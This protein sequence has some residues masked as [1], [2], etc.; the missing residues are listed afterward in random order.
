MMS[1]WNKPSH[2]L[3]F[4]TL[5]MKQVVETCHLATFSSGSSVIG[6]ITIA[7]TDQFKRYRKNIL[8]DRL[9]FDLKF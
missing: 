5:H 8:N 1:Q 2:F 3:S 7:I 4:I 9:N 6:I